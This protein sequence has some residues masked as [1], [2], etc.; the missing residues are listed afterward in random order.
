MFENVF[1]LENSLLL[2]EN[3]FDLNYLCFCY[4]EIITSYEQKGKENIANL[5]KEK[6][7]KTKDKIK[8]QNDKKFNIL[9]IIKPKK[10]N[11][12]E[13]LKKLNFLQ[14]NN[15]N[16][17]KEVIE[18][19]KEKTKEFLQNY[20]NEEKNM[21][22]YIEKQKK[23]FK[24]KLTK[25]RL[26]KRKPSIEIEKKKN[27]THKINHK[28]VYSDYSILADRKFTLQPNCLLLLKVDNTKQKL[29]LPDVFSLNFEKIN[30]NCLRI[31]EK[32]L[33]KI[34]NILSELYDE[35]VKLS[36]RVIDSE[37][38]KDVQLECKKEMGN[39]AS[40][41]LKK[42]TSQASIIP[43]NEILSNKNIDM[44]NISFLNTII[45]YISI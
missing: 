4:Q 38:N 11:F 35:K 32:K 5:Y 41:N 36:N 6:L 34:N 44:I 12:S 31:Y 24:D 18:K 40:N 13:F 1:K 45:K 15:S 28:T 8:L 19:S 3:I 39:F 14:L 10:A 17:E 43:D 27:D 22:Y 33:E 7:K 30:K 16:K 26:N 23:Q 20:Q 42:L 37:N 2:F 21:E 9:M 25:K 29:E